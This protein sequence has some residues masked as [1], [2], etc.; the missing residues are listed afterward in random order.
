MD[1]TIITY[2]FE[3]KIGQHLFYSCFVNIMIWYFE[4]FNVLF[5]I[6]TRV[7]FSVFNR[8]H[9]LDAH[10]TSCLT[11]PSGTTH[12]FWCATIRRTNPH[13]TDTPPWIYLIPHLTL[14]RNARNKHDST[15]NQKMCKKMRKKKSHKIKPC[16]IKVER[17]F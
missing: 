6:E 5:H 13:V 16:K 11:V 8:S 17:T 15:Q 2:H 12:L 1:G 10:Y 9:N 4:T 7:F 14:S 3:M